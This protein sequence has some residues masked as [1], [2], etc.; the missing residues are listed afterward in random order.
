MTEQKILPAEK[1]AARLKGL[2]MPPAG[3]REG[4]YA[5]SRFPEAS[6]KP[7]RPE[8]RTARLLPPPIHKEAQR[9]E[10]PA[11]QYDLEQQVGSQPPPRENGK[12]NV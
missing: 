5:A 11:R 9:E 4:V 7:R 12:L 8:V 3:V 2:H 1:E 6:A 10:R